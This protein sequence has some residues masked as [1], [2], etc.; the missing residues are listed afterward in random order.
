MAPKRK[1]E[2]SG[3]KFGHLL[4]CVEGEPYVYITTGRKERQWWCMCAC[5]KES[6][7]VRQTNLLNGKTKSCGCLKRKDTNVLFCKTMSKL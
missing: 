5:G 6:V 1:Y 7:L 3:Q 2:L 4:V